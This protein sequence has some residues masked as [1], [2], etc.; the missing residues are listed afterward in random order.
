[1]DVPTPFPNE[2]VLA[3][4]TILRAGVIPLVQ[5]K[6]DLLLI[7]FF[8]LNFFFITYVVDIEQ[9]IVPDPYH[10]QQPLWPPAPMLDMIHH[11]G[12]T[13]DPLLMARPQWWKMTIWLD[14]LFYGPFYALA[15][16]AFLKGKE[17]IRIPCFF[18]AGM[19]FADVFIILGEESAGPYA[20]PHLPQVLA[21]NLPWLL[22]P[23]LLTWR[24]LP[25]HPF[26]RRA[27]SSRKH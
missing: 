21:L 25:E 13:L 11:Y 7:A 24:M 4:K 23:F 19:M 14:V 16:F 27:E 17:W 12:Q 10:Y 5:R 26:M 6:L 22:I 15:M 2:G 20:A 3:Q 18:Y 1:M 9:L 8:A